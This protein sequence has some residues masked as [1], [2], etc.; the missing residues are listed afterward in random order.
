MAKIGRFKNEQARTDFLRFYAEYEAT[1]TVPATTTD[2]STSFGSTHVRITGSGTATPVVLLHGLGG[3]SLYWQKYVERFGD[4]KVY[5][6][7]TIG[8]AGRSVQTEPLKGEESFA[9]WFTDVLDAL[10]LDRVHVV[11]LSHGAWHA[12]LI[13]L[14]APDRLASLTMIEPGGMFAKPKTSVLLKMLW[15]GIQGPEK[16]FRKA[17]EWL[18]PGVT[19]TELETRGAKAALGYRMGLGWARVLKDEELQALST[20]ALAICGAESIVSSPEITARRLSEHA[21]HAETEIFPDTAHGVLDQIPDQVISRI[22]TFL[23]AHDSAPAE[24]R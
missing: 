17:G 22:R 14:H 9:I 15:L 10:G 21:R 3:N 2:V 13:A 6:L 24:I 4:R 1:C 20:P 19:L 18:T 7:D 8:A 5:A 16:G 11:G 23:G 12:A